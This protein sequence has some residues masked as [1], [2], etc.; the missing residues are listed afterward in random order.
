MTLVAKMPIA[1]YKQVHELFCMQ[2]LQ[3]I[4]FGHADCKCKEGCKGDPYKK[5]DCD[6]DTPPANETQ[7]DQAGKH[8]QYKP[9][10]VPILQNVHTLLSKEINIAPH[11][12]LLSLCCLSIALHQKKLQL[13]QGL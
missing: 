7:A 3:G 2:L 6:I 10:P 1:G 12:V 11:I 13:Q 9:P 4:V 5:C 8:Q